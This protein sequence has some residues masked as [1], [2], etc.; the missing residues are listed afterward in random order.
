MRNY[1]KTDYAINRYSPNIV[2]RFD[3]EIVE[4]TPEDYLKENPD[5]TRQDF[6]DLKA[7]SDDIYYEQDRLES[8]QTRKD[9]SIHGL[10]EMDC[11]ATLPLEDEWE[12]LV[13]A[14]Q[15]RRNARLTLKQL[16][17]K[18]V[19][20]KAQKRRF[21]LYLFHGLSTR[22]IGRMEGVSH[23]AVAKSFSQAIKKLKK[24]FYEQG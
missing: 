13:T 22:Q 15:N 5:K 20:T 12:E 4:V 10:E 21:L 8:A 3:N 9:I 11:C 16:L 6:S 17:Y 1:R 2:Y 24:I 19:L 14:I 18:D 7:L 23:Q